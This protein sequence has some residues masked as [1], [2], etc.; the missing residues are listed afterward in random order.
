MPT[1]TIRG[2]SADTR[3]KLKQRAAR[4]DRSMEAEARDILDNAVQTRPTFGQALIALGDEIRRE[5]GGVELEIP[6]MGEELREN[7][8]AWF[9]DE[10]PD[11]EETSEP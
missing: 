10:Y 8:L 5:M 4:N 7:P 1:L 2:L 3:K 9:F 6:R 11:E